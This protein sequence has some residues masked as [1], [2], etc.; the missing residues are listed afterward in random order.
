MFNSSENLSEAFSD[1]VWTRF[2]N[3]VVNVLLS[4]RLNP[5]MVN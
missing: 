5:K 3:Q 4:L 1:L 2:A